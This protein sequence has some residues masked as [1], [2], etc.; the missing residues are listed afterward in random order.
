M[1][2][3][4]HGFNSSP[5]SGKAQ[6]CIDHFAK[7]GWSCLVPALAP[8]P[9]RAIASLR[10]LCVAAGRQAVLAGSS[11]GGFYA[12]WLVENGFAPRAI[13]INPA[14]AADEKLADEVGKTQ[15]NW[16]SGA[17][18]VFSQE[19]AHSL[20]ELVVEEISDSSRYLLMAQTGDEVLD[21][22]EADSY[23]QDCE[24]IIEPGGDHGF[25][26]FERHLNTIA[27]AAGCA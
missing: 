5:R 26:G 16:H 27:Q 10:C 7:L 1:L 18:Y 2:I 21:W 20:R 6:A 14:V 3:Y 13:L 25:A 17:Q 11:L 19:Y 12:T 15:R 9:A 24:K 22:Q 23:Y 4:I 8:D